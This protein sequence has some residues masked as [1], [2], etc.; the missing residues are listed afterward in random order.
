MAKEVE[1]LARF[2]AQTQ[3]E[4]IPAEVRHYAKLM[5]LDTLGIM[6]VG[7][8]Q[9]EV[10]GLRERLLATTGSGATVLAPGLPT[11]DPRTAA[12][13]NG[14]AGRSV[15]L[16][17]GHRFISCQGVVQALPT[18]LAVGEWAKST[19]REM[20]SAL[21]L[22][23]DVAARLAAGMKPRA[24]AH[25]NGQTAMLGAVAAGS[26]LRGLDA[27]ATSLALRVGATLV[28]VPSYNNAVSGSTTLNVAGGMS[29]YAGVLA[30]DLALAGFAAQADG[31]EEALGNL[32]GDGYRPEP[33]LEELGRR[34]EITR[35]FTRLR[36]CCNPIYSALDSLEA[37]LAELRPKPE[38]VD[39][40]DVATY[41]FAS[42][43][44]NP[45]PPNY[46]GAKY[47]LPHAAAAIVI[48]GNA[49][50]GSFTEEVVHDPAI[51]AMRHRV[52]ISED[53]AMT[54]KAP[55]LK[56]ARVTVTLKNGKSSTHAVDSPRGDCL[57]PYDENELRGK[58][59]ELAGIAL[60]T[61]AGVAELEKLVDRADEWAG[62]GELLGALKK[63]GLNQG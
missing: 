38:D 10:R 6:L 51:A 43:M 24:L 49:G 46:F 7:A 60:A 41:R 27:A 39:R 11:A 31:I 52:H 16:C 59:R 40:I 56:A 22:G 15:E 3:W 57:H 4:E 48:R 20:M 61:P 1:V 12:L 13:L 9:P 34:W 37:C 58:F 47:S 14:I 30:P 32:V 2:A 36:A 18:V 63:Y 28:L 45:D 53:P 17:E 23:Y 5:F 19:G 62:I 26:R 8:R 54:A 21:V 35:N 55:A 42:A 33:V 25:Q 29:G 44:R 50:Y